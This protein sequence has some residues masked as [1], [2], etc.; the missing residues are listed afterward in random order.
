MTGTNVW[1]AILVAKCQILNMFLFMVYIFLFMDEIQHNFQIL[2]RLC[3]CLND[4]TI[5]RYVRSN[6][7]TRKVT[8]F[9]IAPR[10]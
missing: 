3:L 7:I 8:L 5:F 1:V 9:M 2:L 4:Q 10:N 6:I